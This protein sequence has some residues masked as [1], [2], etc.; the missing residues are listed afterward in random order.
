MQTR[1]MLCGL[2]AAIIVW[3]KRPAERQSVCVSL[4]TGWWPLDG[5]TL[6]QP[7]A[8]LSETDTAAW[9]LYTLA[10]HPSIVGC[11][12]RCACDGGQG[13]MYILTP[14]RPRIAA[15]LNSANAYKY[16]WILGSLDIQLQ[17]LCLINQETGYERIQ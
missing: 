3:M 12:S 17:H 5:T 4:L 7:I 9:L 8:Q 2:A 15:R 16:I 10:L 13:K 6:H 14:S 11:N 1:K